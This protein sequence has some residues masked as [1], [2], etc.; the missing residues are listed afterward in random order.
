MTASENVRHS[1]DLGRDHGGSAR[2]VAVWGKSQEATEWIR[3]PSMQ[4][5][6]RTIGLSAG[7]ISACCSGKIKQTN[8]YVFQHAKDK[9]VTC[10]PGEEWREAIL[11]TRF[12]HK[13]MSSFI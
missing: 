13:S 7:G 3:Y 5:A 10:Y 1:Y 4:N 12:I 11:P 8:G 2:S 9:I 6:A